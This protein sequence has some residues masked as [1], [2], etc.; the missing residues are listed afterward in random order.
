MPVDETL[1]GF[2][3]V[4]ITNFDPSNVATD[5]VIL[6]TFVID[7]SGS[8]G[9]FVNDLN[10]VLNQFVDEI[11]K[12][13][14]S[15]KVLVQTILFNGDIEV[16]H[17]FKPITEVAKFDIN[18]RGTTALFDATRFALENAIN[19]KTDLSNQG[20]TAKSLVFILTDGED[21][22]S[23]KTKPIQIRKII[24]DIYTN[25]SFSNEF[26]VMAFGLGND[27][28]FTKIFLEMGIKQELIAKVGVDA[29]SLRGMI[30]FISSSVSSSGSGSVPT[31]VTF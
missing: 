29:K 18:T 7:K 17:G 28:D 1:Q 2:G 22:A 4:Q 25:E 23:S 19:Y 21:N 14:V 5:D 24:N 3:N 6:V 26:T 13:H 12:S 11:G 8:V 27:A 31:S 15:D 16:V 20:L 9:S 30:G 10:D